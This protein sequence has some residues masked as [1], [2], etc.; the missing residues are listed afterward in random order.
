MGMNA[1]IS[2]CAR[3]AF[4]LAVRYVLLRRWVDVFFSETEVDNMYDVL[5]PVGV[6][7]DQEILRLYVTI[8]QMFRVDVFYP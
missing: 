3:E 1:H 4:V 5:L 7:T 6:P 8:D 2:S